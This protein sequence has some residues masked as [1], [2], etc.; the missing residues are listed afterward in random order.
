MTEVSKFGDYLDALGDTP[1]ADEARTITGDFDPADALAVVV[2]RLSTAGGGGSQTLAEVLAEG[3]D[4]GNQ[5]IYNASSVE[6]ATIQLPRSGGVGAATIRHVTADPSAG[7]GLT[8][9]LG[10]LVLRNTGS[11]GQLWQKT[12]AGNTDW[13]LF[14]TTTPSPGA[15]TIV[16]VGFEDILAN[17]L[18]DGSNAAPLLTVPEN[19]LATIIGFVVTEAFDDSSVTG[20]DTLQVVDDADANNFAPWANADLSA[21]SSPDYPPFYSFTPT[22]TVYFAP[23]DSPFWLLFDSGWQFDGAAGSVD[24]IV[25]I[26]RSG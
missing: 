12:G 4:A 13:E 15:L 21:A 14:G 26:E 20:S 22:G 19:A 24:V 8:A 18:G 23:T 6:V 17:Q 3:G 11:T 9:G 10:A 1:T 7:G 2:E 16:T 5:I 25:K